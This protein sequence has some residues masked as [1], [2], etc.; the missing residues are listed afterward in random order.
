VTTRDP[1]ELRRKLE[2]LKQRLSEVKE[3]GEEDRIERGADLAAQVNHR[4]A[5]ALLSRFRERPEV[6]ERLVALGLAEESWLEEPPAE[7]AELFRPLREVGR[8]LG[9]VIRE[10]PSVLAELRTTAL[11]LLAGDDADAGRPAEALPAVPRA[12]R[13][14][15]FTDLEGFTAFTAAEGDEAAGR[16]LSGHASH[17]GGIVR[18]RGG[19]VVKSLG[20]G[21][22]LVF[23]QPEAGV[24]ASLEL[25]EAAP[26]PLRLRAG[27]HAGEVTIADEDLLGH[28]VNVAARVTGEAGGGEALVTT[29]VRD[30]VQSL[31]Q[32]G[33]GEPAP[34]R[35]RGIEEPV[36]VCAV[37]RA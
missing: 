20:D 30:R 36:A 2:A 28:V 19:R 23:E 25:V 34:R 13:T 26:D 6:F 14:V 33:F 31:P 22:M 15:V 1:G 7:G 10:N 29:A 9:T 27:G 11:D 5:D 37:R 17:V 8:N 18:S 21:H 16:L 24:L 32:I 4:I 12:D 35:L 3:S